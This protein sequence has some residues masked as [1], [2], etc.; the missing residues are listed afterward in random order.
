MNWYRVAQRLRHLP[1]LERAEWIWAPL[2]ARFRQRAVNGVRIVVGGQCQVLMPSEFCGVDWWNY[3]PE[4]IA[5]LI[6]WLDRN[7][8]GTVIDIGCSVGIF[9]VTALFHSPRARVLAI[10]PNATSVSAA[11]RMCRFAT[12]QRLMTLHGFIAA[13]NPTGLQ[14]KEAIAMSDARLQDGSA[15]GATRFIC[16]SDHDRP[17]SIPTY[18]IDGL[19]GAPES[20]VLEDGPLLL[21]CDVEGAELLVLEGARRCLAERSPAI[22]LSVHPPTLGQYGHDV[23]DVRQFLEAAGYSTHVLAVDHEEHWWCEKREPDA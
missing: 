4:S 2:R 10:D 8:G 18:S 3:E 20:S 17:A 5:A 22:L 1:L 11:Q 21:K 7:P 19:L 9:S 15:A 14:L 13:D 23:G 12:G 16:L 6:Q